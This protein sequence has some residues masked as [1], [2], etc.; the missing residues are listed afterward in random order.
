MLPPEEEFDTFDICADWGG[1]RR[2]LRR[3]LKLRWLKLSRAKSMKPESILAEAERL[4]EGDRQNSYGNPL[5]DYSRTAGMINSAF[6][7][8]L[9]EPLT[10]EDIM[11]CM[12]M[13]KI[14]REC[15][16]HK[17]DNVVDIA[18]YANCIDMAI[19]ERKRRG[20]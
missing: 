4:T 5:D 18:G 6:A 9:K 11:L 1:E 16:E 3:H 15:H 7:H 14:S 19:E 13:V 20:G 10:P 17:R 12:I 2:T 8:K